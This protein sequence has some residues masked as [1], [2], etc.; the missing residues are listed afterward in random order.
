[1][2]AL[3]TPM[4]AEETSAV[5]VLRSLGDRLVVAQMGVFGASI[6]AVRGE[7]DRRVGHAVLR[8]RTR[9]PP[10]ATQQSRRREARGGVR[11][12]RPVPTW[13]T[14]KAQQAST[15]LMRFA[16]AVHSAACA[17]EAAYRTTVMNARSVMHACA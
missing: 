13:S 15:A 16:S 6:P 11:S 4:G 1:M 3:R 14:V 5:S 10:S 17:G 12:G 7:V 8:E 9:R 2:R